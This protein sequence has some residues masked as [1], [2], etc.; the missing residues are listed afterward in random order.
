[1]QIL[2]NSILIL[3][4]C[5]GVIGAAGFTE[6]VQD[7]AYAFF[8]AGILGCIIGG[9]LVRRAT[10]VGGAGTHHAAAAVGDLQ[11]RVESIARRVGTLEESMTQMEGPAFCAEIDDLLAGEYF[12]LGSRSEEYTQLLGFS[13]YAQ[14]WG[15]VAVAERLLARAWSIATDGHL[16][17]AREEVPLARA[18][19]AGA[20]QA[21]E[22][23]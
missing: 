9:V 21:I 22:G 6:P 4:V 18:Q 12:E 16:D 2:A 14:V 10:R 1:M 11:Q 15:G 5:L 20:M 17:E 8:A 7:G 19:L 23:I 13:A 3:G